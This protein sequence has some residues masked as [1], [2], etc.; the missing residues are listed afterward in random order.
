M[1]ISLNIHFLELL[2]PGGSELESHYKVGWLVGCHVTETWQ[3]YRSLKIYTSEAPRG[4]FYYY[5]CF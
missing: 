3:Y 2:K 4:W 1:D 5:W